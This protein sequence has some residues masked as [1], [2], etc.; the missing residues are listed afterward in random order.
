[1]L[2][3]GIDLCI[4]AQVLIEFWAVATRPLSAN[5]LGFTA[6]QIREQMANLRGMFTVLPE[7]PDMADLW[8]D[9]SD[10]HL[11]Q[12]KQAHDARITALML[13]HGL[14]RILTFNVNDFA[15][16]SDISAVTPQDILYR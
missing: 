12:G 16:Y 7:P 5:G 8:Q 14:T 6:R 2:D 4:C 3:N 1:M 11:V 13:V 9:V 15:R 10:K